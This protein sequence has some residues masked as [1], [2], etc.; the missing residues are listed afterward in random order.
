MLNN[1]Q[2]FNNEIKPGGFC[3]MHFLLKPHIDDHPVLKNIDIDY[4]IKYWGA[5]AKNVIKHN[6]FLDKK[7]KSVRN[8][9][10]YTQQIN[11]LLEKIFY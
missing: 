1:H 11:D 2:K 5:N 4:Y 7:M 9:K 3:E 10:F 6:L 8:N